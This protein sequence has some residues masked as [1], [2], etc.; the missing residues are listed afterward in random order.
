MDTNPHSHAAAE[1]SDRTVTEK[2]WS[3]ETNQR[4]QQLPRGLSGIWHRLTGQFAKVKAQNEMETLLA[5]QRDRAEKD[6]LIFEQL[7]ERQVLQTDIKKQRAIVQNELMLLREDVANQQAPEGP[8]LER[9]KK[10]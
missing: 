1:R 9:G 6:A 3:A 4:A 5:W 8:D 10:T 2:R 7:K